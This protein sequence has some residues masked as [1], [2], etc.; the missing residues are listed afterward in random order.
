MKNVALT[1][2]TILC[3]AIS[4]KQKN[5]E[6]EVKFFP[7]LDFLK[8][9]VADIDSSV[10][11]L[12][13]IVKVDSIADTSFIKKDEFKT[14]ARYFTSLPDISSENLKD[15]YTATEMFDETIGRVVLNYTP[16][17]TAAEIRRQ[18]VQIAPDQAGDKVKALIIDR[19]TSKGDST[20]QQRMFWQVDKRF[21]IVTIVQKI[22]QP[23]KITT[24]QIIWNDFPATQ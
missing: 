17:N 21:Q 13:K 10:H 11:P 12:M 24:T 15:E 9:Q 16:K 6:E 22:K 23:D 4:C 20:V 2:C 7:V 14:Y 5:K 19:L 1:F 3:V 18:E 8:A